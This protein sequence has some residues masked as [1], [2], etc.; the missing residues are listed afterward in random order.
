MNQGLFFFNQLSSLTERHSEVSQ[1]SNEVK[2]ENI[3][4]KS[5]IERRLKVFISKTLMSK[6]HIC[7]AY[8]QGG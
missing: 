8:H 5:D 4:L 1:E 7:T 6:Y 3:Q 2:Q